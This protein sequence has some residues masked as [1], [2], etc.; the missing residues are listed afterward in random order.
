MIYL[1]ILEIISMRMEICIKEHCPKA[2]NME[3][4]SIFMQMAT[5]FKAIGLMIR[6]KVMEFSLIKLIQNNTKE[7]FQ[8]ILNTAKE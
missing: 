6:K 4:D 8:K 3:K 7:C 1:M 2:K 5:F